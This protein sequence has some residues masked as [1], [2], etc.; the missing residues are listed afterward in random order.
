MKGS[1]VYSSPG[2][3]TLDASVLRQEN[4][5]EFLHRALGCIDR[6]LAGHGKQV[7][8]IASCMV[9]MYG[10]VEP[11]KLREISV[12]ALLHDMGL[13]KVPWEGEYLFKSGQ[14]APNRHAVYGELLYAAAVKSP[15]ALA[16]R[17]HHTPYDHMDGVDRD[18]VFLAQILHLADR[19]AVMANQYSF[20]A[21]DLDGYMMENC[22]TLF[23][24]EV[25]SLFRSTDFTF[26]VCH[27]VK[28]GVDFEEIFEGCYFSP[29]EVEAY[30]RLFVLMADYQR[31]ATAADTAV[32]SLLSAGLA[33]GLG[34]SL[35]QKKRVYYGALLYG[36]GKLNGGAVA[37][38]KGEP[39]Q[40]DAPATE[41]LRRLWKLLEGLLEP[42]VVACAC[43]PHGLLDSYGRLQAAQAEGLSQQERVVALADSVA[44]L[45]QPGK[46]AEVQ[47]E[48]ITG[49]IAEEVRQG[50]LDKDT[51]E[52][53]CGQYDV[54]MPGCEEASV[55]AAGSYR[56][57]QREYE[58]ALLSF[59]VE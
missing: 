51:S 12:L 11:Q 13:C 19:A 31:E 42:G 9:G 1:E 8:Y 17:Y 40:A 23:S 15:L 56:R 58:A 38:N 53:F 24:Q 45:Y 36:L 10:G 26:D 18:I 29:D 28:T 44:C 21:A 16:L 43:N 14:S 6:R 46:E 20:S 54:L 7:A 35:P 47:K 39:T 37:G 3:I 22:G 59:V 33:D 52:V 4:M 50:R 5:P 25:V 27:R 34:F 57:I 55:A 30:L 41:E 2:E 32:R 49:K 48:F